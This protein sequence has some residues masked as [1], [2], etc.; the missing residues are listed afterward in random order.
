MSDDNDG[1][2]YGYID[3]GEEEGEDVEEDILDAR[4]YSEA[5][6]WGMT[7]DEERR[8]APL[9]EELAAEEPDTAAGDDRPRPGDPVPDEYLP[10]EPPSY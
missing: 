1:D 8:G 7:A 4:D 10:E 6:R 2:P 5:D 3:D 9:A